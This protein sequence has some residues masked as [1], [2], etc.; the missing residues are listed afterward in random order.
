MR[1]AV[2]EVSDVGAPLVG[3]LLPAGRCPV[4]GIANHSPAVT[5]AHCPFGAVVSTVRRNALRPA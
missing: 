4:K 2:G 3:A 5:S 1:S